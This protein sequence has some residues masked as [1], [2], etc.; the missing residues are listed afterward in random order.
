[1][2]RDTY[3]ISTN[4][5]INLDKNKRKILAGN[6]CIENYEKK[7][8][9]K[10][11]E[12]FDNIWKD[13]QK[14]NTYYKYLHKISL[15]YSERLGISALIIEDKKGLKKNSL[16]SDTSLQI[17]EDKIKFSEKIQ[18]GKKA[19]MSQEF[20]I[21]ARIE[22]F[23]L[24]KGIKDAIARAHSYVDAGADGIMIHSKSSNPSEI[25]EFSKKFRKFYKEIPLI[26]V[27][28]SYNHVRENVLKEN[29]FNIVIYAN[30]MLRASYPSMQNVAKTILKNQRSKE[31]DKQ[32][33][34]IKQILNLIPGAN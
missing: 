31:S 10:R 20:M 19:Q 18:E 26:S 12:I 16:L 7:E 33:L 24:G 30:H 14:Y 25:F 17:Q 3:F 13:K 23:I 9:L 27:P 1:M 11:Y 34:S 4:L 6:W 2:L 29:G 21:I 15:R 32:L 8:N 28:S 22:S 5:E